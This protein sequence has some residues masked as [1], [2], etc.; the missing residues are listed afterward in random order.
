MNPIAQAKIDTLNELRG[1]FA[2]CIKTTDTDASN[3]EEYFGKK[4]LQAYYLGQRSAYN[5]VL[6]TIDVKIDCI[7]K[8]PDLQ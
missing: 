7:T 6:Q 8:F 3:V 1:R 5:D 2:D 4:E